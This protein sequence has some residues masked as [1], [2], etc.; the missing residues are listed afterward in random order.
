M[1]EFVEH[2]H[3]VGIGGAGMSGIA[4]VLLDLGYRVSGSDFS[5]SRIT[6]RLARAGA[7]LHYRHHSD[8]LGNADVVVYSAAI[9][10]GNPELE[11]A[12]LRKIPVVSRAEMLGEVMRFKKGI[13]I[14][15]THGKT[16]TTSL[17]STLLINAG[18]DPTFIVGGV[19]NSTNTNSRL[20]AG[21]Y[22]VAEA[23]ESDA[24]FLHLQPLIAVVTNIDRDHME[25]YQGKVENLEQA[26]VDFLHNLPFYGLAILCIDDPGV[27]RILHCLNRSCV[28][29]G[30]SDAA[31]FKASRFSQ[32][33]RASTFQVSRSGQPIGEFKLALPGCH[34]VLNALAVIATGFSLGVSTDVI[35]SALSEFEGI[36]RRFEA[37]G[38]IRLAD[39]T[40]E[41]VDD[42]AHHP[43]EIA[44]TL[45]AARDC[46][47]QRR[48]VVVFQPHRY[49]RT[50]DL[51]DDF[52]Q[53]LTSVPVLAITEVYAA[54][55]EPIAGFGGKA[56]S[57]A[58]RKEA[59][60]LEF[61]ETFDDLN[62]IL[63]KMTRQDD[64]LITMG[65]GSIGQFAAELSAGQAM[66]NSNPE[67]A[68][69]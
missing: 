55:E 14:T 53:I 42:Y 52:V 4:E 23:D 2:V 64:V 44:A 59:E 10:R 27:Q 17:V 54:G 22:L 9:D 51:F 28:T 16:T 24:S 65:A 12:R 43:S 15:G 47:P 19:I 34:N 8:N 18:T 7:E 5:R 20:G 3:F 58:I 50:R 36:S 41:L 31:D 13:A 11:A 33:G 62:S 37:L 39:H 6:Q 68:C 21:E 32:A 60:T 46:W 25:T 26:Y 67:Q 69:V 40:V 30:F 63:P 61:A 66:K 56:L 29:Y 1:R 49:S 35:R 48:L 45:R 38:E 57:D